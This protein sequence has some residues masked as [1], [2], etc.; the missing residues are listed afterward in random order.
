[1]SDNITF[2]K[3][4][5]IHKEII[6][7]W[8]A[9]SHAQ[10]FWDNTQEHKDDIINFINGRVKPSNYCDGK[11]LYWIATAF[12]KP[13][14]MLMTIQE[15]ILDDIGDLK[16]AHLSR[17]GHTYGIDF[18]IGN[19]DYLGKGYGAK[20]LVEFMNYF[21][22]TFDNKAD[23][24]LIDPAKDNPRAKHVYEKAG[25]AYIDDFV[26]AGDCSG[27]GKLH[28]LLIKKY[29]PK[30]E[31]EPVDI[32]AHS[33]IQNMARFYLYDLSKECGHISRDWRLPQDGLYENFNLK[34]YFEDADRKAYLIKVY[35]EV[36]GF[37][38]LNR[39]VSESTS[40]WNMGEFFI[41]G[42]FQGHG[43]GKVAAERIWQ[44]H[45]G[46][47]EVS[48][49]PENY[50]AISFWDNIISQFSN[51]NFKRELKLIDFDKDQPKRIIFY[52]NSSQ[53]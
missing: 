21:R 33:M 53:I 22:S 1:M 8:L 3:V 4:T 5:N 38:L 43:V 17:T 11:Y 40:D 39:A 50:S 51:D 28:H 27:A 20:T 7:S 26:M 42:R 30:V 49:I 48:V 34:N 35:H 14:A 37:I 24:F 2:E 44:L 45:P 25:F 16:H 32:S 19:P 10:Q 31:I 9:E 47:W 36:A 6:F 13:Y 15:T 52:F 23:V 18:M 12:D 46:K 41:L 29:L